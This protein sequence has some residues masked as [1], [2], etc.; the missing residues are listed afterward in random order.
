MK[1]ILLLFTDQQRFDTVH[2]LGN[3]VI[4]TPVLDRLV[5]EGVTFRNAYTPC[6]VCVPA[7]FS[8][9]TGEM[10]HDT[11]V[12]ENT[13]IPCGRRSFMEI[14][15]EHGYQ[16][17]G[18][19]KMHFTFPSGP[20]ELWGFDERKVCDNDRD[21]QKNDFYQNAKEHGYGYV[22]DYKG[23]KSEMYY[24]PQV[25]Q[26]PESLHH[27]TWT[28]DCCIDFLNRRDTERPFFIMAGF[29]K[30]HPPFQPPTPWNRLYRGPDMPSP[31]HTE[32]A[33]EMMTYWNHYQNRYKYRDRGEDLNLIRQIK[34]HYYAEIS[35]VDYNVGRI[36]E[37]L[38]EQGVLEDTLI[39]FTADHGEFLGDYHCYGKR[40]FLDSAARV[41]MLMKYP[42]CAAGTAVDTPVSLIDI[43]PT[44]LQYA[45]IA[46]EREYEGVSL[47]DTAQGN[48]RREFVVGEYA[49]DRYAN[50]MIT[51]GR[52]KY[53]YSAPDRKEFLFDHEIDP[54]ELHNK[55][56][57]PLYT[58]K[59][60]ELRGELIRYLR[61]AGY[62][63]AVDG[64]AF[65]EY[66]AV[67]NREDP[68]AYL[69]FQDG[70]D[71]IPHI[72]G[73]MTDSNQRRYFGAYRFGKQDT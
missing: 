58:K 72:D 50:Y 35:L 40:S 8:M 14:L 51:D 45:G 11:G 64:D 54:E 6:P 24:I 32:S 65:R 43:M 23:T 47:L 73:Y 37:H 29:E 28:A 41:P 36:L 7:R 56:Y 48:C 26:L 18:A 21:L 16:T 15:S 1:N 9:H 66:P 27:T 25:S 49:H 62:E 20:N 52:F 3:R 33:D 69:L 34:A 4:Q 30:P 55:A 46:P 5:R 67:S 19:G 63:D 22:Y 68:D 59:K 13:Q 70:A 10:P 39:L 44:F 31:K 61:D 71:S 53:I 2:A 57:L 60:Q 38:E 12:F 42:G 17:F